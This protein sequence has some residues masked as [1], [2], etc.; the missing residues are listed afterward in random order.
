MKVL[1]TGGHGFIGSNLILNMLYKNIGI[2]IIN[3]DSLTYAAR[4]SY[5]RGKIEGQTIFCGKEQYKEII[6]DIRDPE[7]IDKI[8]KEYKPDHIIHLAAESHVCNSI[9]GPRV[10]YETNI[11]GTVNLLE[12]FRKLNNGGRFLHVSTDEVFGELPL[13]APELKFSE[14][15]PVDP[16]SPYASSKASSDHIVQAYHHTYGMNTII[17]NCSNNYGPNQHEEKLIP[18]TIKHLLRGLPVVVHGKGDHVRDWLFVDNHCDG[19]LKAL[20]K[21]ESGERYCFGGSNE[22][23]NLEIINYVKSVMENV[24]EKKVLIDLCHTDDR[25]TDDCR[26]AVDVTKVGNDLGWYPT[27]DFF[28]K[29]K[30]TIQWYAK[31]FNNV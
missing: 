5:L 1:V 23:T 22:K 10:F 17:T 8:F 27:P 31:E 15:T 11:M 2:E 3:L 19:I 13:T 30:E 20:N 24:L 29:I 21:G 16:R 18:R 26:Y 6:A 28:G 25:P 14:T 7:T 9:K 12:S 4:P